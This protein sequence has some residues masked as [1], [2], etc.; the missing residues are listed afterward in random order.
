MIEDDGHAARIPGR[1]VVS[2]KGGS[3]PQCSIVVK[4]AARPGAESDP[5][6]SAVL[7]PLFRPATEGSGPAGKRCSSVERQSPNTLVHPLYACFHALV[8]PTSPANSMA[9]LPGVAS[10]SASRRKLTTATTR[11][12]S[13]CTTYTYFTTLRRSEAGSGDLAVWRMPS[14][15]CSTLVAVAGTSSRPKAPGAHIT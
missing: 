5:I 1:A 6:Q 9:K 12:C 2:K 10:I 7:V 14:N 4:G 11:R 8:R 15:N 3:A 13:G